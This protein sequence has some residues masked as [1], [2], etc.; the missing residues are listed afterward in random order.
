MIDQYIPSKEAIWK[1]ILSFVES[2]ILPS[3]N[4]S[5]PRLLFLDTSNIKNVWIKLICGKQISRHFWTGCIENNSFEYM[6]K[7][8]NL[9]TTS[10]RK[11]YIGQ[12]K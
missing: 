1:S 4:T 3:P 5:E 2:G 9:I 11:G 6:E 12:V 7:S 8:Q 10:L